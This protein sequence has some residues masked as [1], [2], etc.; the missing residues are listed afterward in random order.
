ML[1]DVE[2]V[3]CRAHPAYVLHAA[4]SYLYTVLYFVFIFPLFVM[5]LVSLQP[6]IDGLAQD[7]ATVVT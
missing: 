5:S 7:C 1:L 6:Y 4:M 3:W 2:F